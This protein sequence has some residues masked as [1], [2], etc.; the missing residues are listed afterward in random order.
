MIDIEIDKGILTYLGVLLG[1]VCQDAMYSG[2]LRFVKKCNHL[3]D[4]AN[5]HPAG[6]LRHLP[7]NQHCQT[8]TK[9]IFIKFHPSIHT[10]EN[11]YFIK[12]I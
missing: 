4:P 1:N 3:A 8:S 10:Q 9:G 12:L 2:A 6:Y 11:C 7:S 5:E